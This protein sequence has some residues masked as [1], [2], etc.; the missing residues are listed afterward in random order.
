[1]TTPPPDPIIAINQQI[2]SEFHQNNRRV[3]GDFEGSPMLILHTIGAKSGSARVTPLMCW[4]ED[5][6]YL[7]IASD[8]GRDS[9]PAWC[10]NLAAHPDTQIEVGSDDGVI[11]VD[12]TATVMPEPERSIFYGEHAARYPGFAR[13][14]ENTTRVIPVVALDPR[15]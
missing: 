1:M 4:P 6:R 7:I 5:G 15:R 12:V 14:Q 8:R 9:S 13:H 11:T 10:H 3:G 2:I